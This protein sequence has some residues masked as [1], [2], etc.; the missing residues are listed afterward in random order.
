MPDNFTDRGGGGCMLIVDKKNI[1]GM[2]GLPLKAII[3]A[4]W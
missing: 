4:K 2:L 1:S 3:V